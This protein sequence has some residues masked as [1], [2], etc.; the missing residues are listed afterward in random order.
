MET[1]MI[2]VRLK[3]RNNSENFMGHK[4]QNP[5][6]FHPMPGGTEKKEGEME[7]LTGVEPMTYSL[8]MSR[9]TN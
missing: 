2:A 7:P 8:R 3:P 6:L 9:S 5:G 1:R 4:L